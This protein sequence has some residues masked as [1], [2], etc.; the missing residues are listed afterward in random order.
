M[1][2][3]GRVLQI[4][5]LGSFDDEREAA[6]AYDKAALQAIGPGAT[7]NFDAEGNPNPLPEASEGPEGKL[8]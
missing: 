5:R 1:Y 4:R 6:R 8:L 7:L 2:T 3:C